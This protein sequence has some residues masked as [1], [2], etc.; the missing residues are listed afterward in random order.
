MIFKT[1]A[2][3]IPQIRAVV[4]TF[5]GCYFHGDGNIYAVDN[6]GNSEESDFR[7]DFSN[8]TNEESRYRVKFQRGDR[9]QKTVEQLNKALMDAKTQ[10]VLAKRSITQTSNVRTFE[11]TSE[12][13]GL[14]DS[15]I[16]DTD[17]EVDYSKFDRRNK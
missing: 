10:E 8:D 9:I 7:K 12:D 17:S 11:V 15:E 5:G 3:N 14:S 4:A 2:S 16:S 1:H 6:N 13:E